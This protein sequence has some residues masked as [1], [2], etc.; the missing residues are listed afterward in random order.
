MCDRIVVMYA[1]RVAEVGPT[2]QVFNRPRHPY[3]AGLHD[4]TAELGGNRTVRPIPGQP[5]SVGERINGCPFA[6]RCAHAQQRCRD[7]EVELLAAGQGRVACVRHDE[8]ELVRAT[9]QEVAG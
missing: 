2:G 6:P 9:G 8:L 7:W 5:P 3:T 1:G 4:S